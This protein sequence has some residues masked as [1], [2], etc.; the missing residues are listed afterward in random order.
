MK[1]HKYTGWVEYLGY[2]CKCQSGNPFTHFHPQYR[3]NDWKKVT[4][5]KCLNKRLNVKQRK[6]GGCDD[7]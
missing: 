4:C 1:V 7:R 3:T 2:T 6:S 5:K